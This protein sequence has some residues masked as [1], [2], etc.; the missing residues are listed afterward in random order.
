VSVLDSVRRSP[1]L[2]E[3]VADAVRRGADRADAEACFPDQA[4]AALRDAGLVAAAIPKEFGGLGL[5]IAESARIASQ[6][7]RGC[8]STAMIW[9]MHQA[10]VA[11]VL[12]GSPPKESEQLLRQLSASQGL[13]ASVTSEVRIGGDIRRSGA[14]LT[15]TDD[16]T[17]SLEKDAPTVS[18][19]GYA[20]AFL[21]TCRRG[22]DSPPD[23]QVAVFAPRAAVEMEQRGD[24]DPMGMRGTVSPPFAVR[25]TVTAGYVLPEPFGRIASRALVPWSHILWASC[26]HG[27]AQEAVARARRTI[28]RKDSDGDLRLADVTRELDLLEAVI[29]QA[30]ERCVPLHED[31]PPTLVAWFNDLKLTVSELA[32]EIAVQCLEICG[33]PGFQERS[34]HS[35]ARILRDLH[36]APLM[37][38]NDRLRRTNAR[39]ALARGG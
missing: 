17:L 10:Q 16:G 36:S 4:F 11:S 35:I 23:D 25:A 27:L 20:D 21:I 22:P 18:Y 30:L 3:Q 6:L 7:A 38:G 32:V 28:R 9:A 26:W 19:G 31:P 24:W 12:A 15:P 29:D 37:I 8:G 13:I 5:S 33:M 34:A 14:A 39:Y 2:H 1:V